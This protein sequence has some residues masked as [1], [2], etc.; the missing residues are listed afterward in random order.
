MGKKKVGRPSSFTAKIAAEAVKHR[1]NGL[2][3]VLIARIVR[4]NPDTLYRWVAEGKREGADPAKR[5]F[6]E[7][8]SAAWAEAASDAIERIKAGDEATKGL[9]WWLQRTGPAHFGE[10]RAD[11][12]SKPRADTDLD[13]ADKT[14]A[15]KRAELMR[16]L[17]ECPPE[18]LRAA[19]AMAE[20]KEG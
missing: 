16:V 3:V 10:L 14:D 20:A 5:A 19:L 11:G 15:D 18:V 7:D 2:T 1:R 9:Q 6:S 17:M 12:R 13:Q 4:L 8:F